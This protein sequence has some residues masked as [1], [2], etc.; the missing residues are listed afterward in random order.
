MQKSKQKKEKSENEFIIL[1]YA[2]TFIDF[3]TKTKHDVE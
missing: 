3:N 1:F 2:K